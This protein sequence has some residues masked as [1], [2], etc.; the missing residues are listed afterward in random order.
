MKHDNSRRTALKSFGAAAGVA[1]LGSLANARETADVGSLVP[2]GASSLKELDERIA[3]APRR[4]A[5]KTVPMILSQ[6]DEWDHEAL[7]E[8]IAYRGSRRQVW[9][10][11]DLGGPWLNLMRNVLNAQVWSF[12]HPD[13]LVVSATHGSAHLSLFDQAA[14]DKYDLAKLAG[15]TFKSNTLIT[16]PTPAG[17]DAKQFQDP[18]GPFSAHGNNIPTLQR[19]GVVFLGCHNAIWETAQKL[20]AANQN[21]DGLPLD[22]LAADLTNHVLPSV[23]VT[24]GVVATVAELE[25]GGFQ[26][27]R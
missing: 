14:W 26:Y 18:A 5:F 10:N 21:P 12:K 24:P 20:V 22:A 7:S 23:I 11:T 8:L 4:R 19:R 3:A 16:E 15:G 27:A 1:C 17:G 9:D 13:F 6:P 25:H 2:G